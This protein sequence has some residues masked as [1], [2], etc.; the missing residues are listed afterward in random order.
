[1]FPALPH[2][3]FMSLILTAPGEIFYRN[4]FPTNYLAQH[5]RIDRQ[6]IASEIITDQGVK[7]FEHT[8][9]P[10]PLNE[11]MTSKSINLSCAKIIKDA[12]TDLCFT[13]K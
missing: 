1:M 9:G 12:W 10:Y 8:F 4:I 7:L 13:E 5:S 2:H 3:D 11:N 6:W